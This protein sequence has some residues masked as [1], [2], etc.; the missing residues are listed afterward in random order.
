MKSLE[1]S[2]ALECNASVV[3]SQHLMNA[4]LSILSGS[5]H[6]E[7]VP[8]SSH[9]DHMAHIKPEK[10]VVPKLEDFLGG[11]TLGGGQFSSNRES[12]HSSLDAICYSNGSS[13]YCDKDTSF[14]SMLF[15][16]TKS[17]YRDL[18]G[19]L[20]AYGMSESD[21]T[22]KHSDMQDQGLGLQALTCHS[23]QGASNTSTLNQG[24]DHLSNDYMFSSNNCNLQLHHQATGGLESGNNLLGLSFMKSWLRS[25]NPGSN[26]SEQQGGA[27]CTNNMHSST[28]NNN[29]SISVNAASA[30]STV[31]DMNQ[32]MGGLYGHHHHH[33]SLSLSMTPSSHAAVQPNSPSTLVSSQAI[34]NGESSSNDL[35]RSSPEKAIV[36]VEQTSRKSIDTFGQRTSIYRG[37]TK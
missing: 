30:N 14:K 22:S 37:V 10:D 5:E 3:E 9:Y 25:Q 2:Q 18:Q 32:G 19:P 27:A 33:Q 13:S 24:Y 17:S 35:K 34:A 8:T 6:G 31:K 16:S 21:L 29:A 20:H 7:H 26:S 11:A 15:A 28:N 1:H 4:E 12:D 23:L 36:P